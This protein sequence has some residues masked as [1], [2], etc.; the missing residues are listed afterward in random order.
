MAKLYFI[1][2]A[3]WRRRATFDLS[4]N[5]IP[6]K[7]LNFTAMPISLKIGTRGLQQWTPVLLSHKV[8]GSSSMPDAPSHGLPNFSHKLHFQPL[9]PSTL[10]CH[11]LFVTS[12]Q[13]WTCY[14]KWGRETSKLLVL[15]PTCTARDLKTTQELWNLQG[16]PSY[17]RGPS[18]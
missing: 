4:S 14:R 5:L 12:S 18:T 1:W 7:V 3:T 10:L 15:N 16:F 2:F 13:L 9:R 8:D 11:N 6:R 17:V